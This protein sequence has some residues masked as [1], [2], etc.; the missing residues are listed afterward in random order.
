MGERLVR[1]SFIVGL[2]DETPSIETSG[3]APQ[4]ATEDENGGAD[5]LVRGRRPR[6]PLSPEQEAGQGAGCGPGGPPHKDFEGVS[7]LQTR[8]SAPRD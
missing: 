2:F 3:H 6:R 1:H 5:P 7:T 4:R 8:V